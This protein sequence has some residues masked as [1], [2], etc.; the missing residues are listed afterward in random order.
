MT[1]TQCMLGWL[2]APQGQM[3][4]GKLISLKVPIAIP[5]QYIPIHMNRDLQ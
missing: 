5:H 4:M 2:A 1:F 3:D